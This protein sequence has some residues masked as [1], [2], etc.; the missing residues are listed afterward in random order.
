MTHYSNEKASYLKIIICDE[1]IM[2]NYDDVKHLNPF[3]FCLHFINFICFRIK[4]VF[5]TIIR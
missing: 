2:T 4:C 3:D 5:R 1:I